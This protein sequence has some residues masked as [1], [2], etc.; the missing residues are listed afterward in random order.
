MAEFIDRDF[1][2]EQ[3]VQKTE[4]KIREAALSKNVPVGYLPIKLSTNGKLGVPSI[5][6]I[7]NFATEDILDLAQAI[8]S[9]LPTKTI[10]TLNRLIFEEAN[11]A[12]WP[13][14]SVI[15][16]LITIYSNF[17]TPFLSDIPFP[18]NDTDIKYLEEKGRLAEAAS[19]KS[20]AWKP[21]SSI[22]LAT[23]ISIETLDPSIKDI[24]KIKK[25]DGS[26]EASFSAFP[27]IGDV[28]LLK[29][30]LD[31]E[32]EKED[33]AWTKF[34][35]KLEIREKLLNEEKYDK[36]PEVTE[37]E[38]IA[39]M[40]YEASRTLMLVRFTQALYLKS[41]MGK[42]VSN[43]TLKQRL[44]YFDDPRMDISVTKKIEE[45]Y[46]KI[47][48]GIQDEIRIMNPITNEMCERRFS[49]RTMD[50]LQAIRAHNSTEY[51][52]SYDDEI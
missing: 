47:K 11:V 33:A 27:R 42:D 46:D 44:R 9:V 19:L 4:T 32:F 30:A 50:I 28:I 16:L 15:E 23:D 39:Y 41:F 21:R 18:W 36:L 20:G 52:I 2:E 25:K 7:R 45:Q 34:K 38:Y 24:V 3:I 1:K 5:I 17:F 26:F 43:E 40:E 31:S 37:K 35:Q 10:Q 14:K 51:D 8:D 22:N 12:H 6:H 13:E 29:E 49:F 48:F